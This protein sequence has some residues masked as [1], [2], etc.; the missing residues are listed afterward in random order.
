MINL[1]FNIQESGK[2]KKFLGVYYEW[3][4]DT[5]FLSEKMTM[6]KDVKNWQKYTGSDVKAQ[7]NPG[8]PGTT[9]S[10]SELEEYYNIDK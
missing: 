1:K 5:K 9:L 4:R 10:K 7:K 8:D 2:V 3:V 6:E